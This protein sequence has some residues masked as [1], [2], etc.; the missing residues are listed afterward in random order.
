M[1]DGQELFD[2]TEV[3]TTTEGIS[4]E[5]PERTDAP[6]DEQGRFSAKDK[7][8]TEAAPA[9]ADGA[10][11]APEKSTPARDI[12]ITAL[13]DEREK[14]QRAEARLAMLERQLQSQQEPQR[15]PDPVEDAEGYTRALHGTFQQALQAQV[16][17]QSQFFAERDFGRDTVADAMA[18]FDQQPRSVSEQF[19]QA[20]SPFH[21]A[22]EWFKARKEAEERASPDFEAKLR[23]KIEAELREKFAAEQ[24]PS[25]ARVP[26]SLAAASGSGRE[27]PP[28]SGDPLLD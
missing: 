6:R 15:L 2:D 5:A 27:P 3:Q 1:T 25:P 24:P 10:P 12:P 20:P 13:L 14:R 28:S 23:A 18:F 7:G 26:R 17:R 22:V 16:L 4:P 8:E 19:L 11:P 21:A 9:A